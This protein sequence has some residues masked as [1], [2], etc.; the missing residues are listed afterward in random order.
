LRYF[1][2]Q[3]D[4]AVEVVIKD[5]STTWIDRE[6]MDEIEK[7]ISNGDGKLFDS[8][9]EWKHSIAHYRKRKINYPSIAEQLDMIY[10]AID[11]DKFDKTSAFYKALKT[12]K[13]KYPKLD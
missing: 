3:D 2:K 12:V 9:S 11:K 5:K 13:N 1:Y 6:D 4:H 7:I 10:H 8:V